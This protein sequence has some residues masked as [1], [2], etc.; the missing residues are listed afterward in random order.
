MERSEERKYFRSGSSRL[1]NGNHDGRQ[2]RAITRLPPAIRIGKISRPAAS[3][4]IG[5]FKRH[6]SLADSSSVSVNQL[7]ALIS[8]RCSTMTPFGCPVEPEV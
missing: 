6:R 8:P 3:K 2:A 5:V 7:T 1:C 4:V